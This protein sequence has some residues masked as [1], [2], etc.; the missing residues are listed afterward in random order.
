MDNPAPCFDLQS[1]FGFAGNLATV[2]VCYF[3]LC[4]ADVRDGR[5]DAPS[6]HHRVYLRLLIIASC[7]SFVMAAT[8]VYLYLRT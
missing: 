4:F 8:S 7:V 1:A 6:V 3:W 2:L 5:L